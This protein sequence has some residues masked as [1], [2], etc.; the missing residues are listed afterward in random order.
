MKKALLLT[1]LAVIGFGHPEANAQK[2]NEFGST[3]RSELLSKDTYVTKSPAKEGPTVFDLMACP[4]GSVYSATYTEDAAF[5]GS[6]CAD[7]GRPDMPCKFFQH[8]SGNKYLVNGV[9]FY[10]YFNYWD[11]ASYNWLFCTERAGIDENGAMTKPVKF[12]ISFYKDNGPDGLAGDEVYKKVVDLIGTQTGVQTGDDVSGYQS[13][14]YF[15]VELDENIKM[16]SGYLQ[17]SAAA[18]DETPTCWFSVFTASSSVDWAYIDAGDFTMDT[19]NPMIFCFKGTGELAADKA[20]KFNRFISPIANTNGKF[21]RVQVEVANTGKNAIE[22]AKLEL[23]ADGKYLTTEDVEETLDPD[24]IYKHTFEARVDCSAPGT[25]K[26]EVRNVTPGDEKYCPDSLAFIVTSQE[27]TGEV[28]ASSSRDCSY[29]HITNVTIGNVS[30]PSEASNYSDFTDIVADIHAGEVLVLKVEVAG[31]PSIAAWVDWNGN[32]ILGENGEVVTWNT[33]D[34]T[35]EIVI[36]ENTTLTEGNKLL[37]IVANYYTPEPV[38]EYSYGETEDYSINVVRNPG[39]PA[40][41]LEDT[42]LVGSLNADNKTQPFRISNSAQGTLEGELQ[43]SYVLPNTPASNYST[44]DPVG[45]DAL[46]VVRRRIAHEAC[47][48]APAA[49]AQTTYTVRYDN[50]Q[51]AAIG[52]N[53]CDNPIYAQLYPGKML[54]A[55]DG[56]QLS[57][58]DVYIG[59]ACTSSKVI[60]YGANTQSAPGDVITTQEFTAVSDSWNH[61]VLNNP[62]TIDGKDLWVCV[63]VEGF[64]G[65]GYH[66]GIDNGPATRG[67][68]ELINIGQS[69]WWSMA[70]LDLDYNLCIRAN[71]SGEATPAISWLSLDNAH[72]NVAANETEEHNLIFDATKIENNKLYEA[73]IDIL[74]NDELSSKVTMPVYLINGHVTGIQT[75]VTE[76]DTRLNVEGNLITVDASK[77]VANVSLFAINGLLAAAVQGNVLDA[78][79]VANGVYVLVVK[80][81]D[82]TNESMKLLFNK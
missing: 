13:I 80:F 19:F 50:G 3:I 42:E 78:S 45:S 52:I 49:D 63:Q 64:T 15:D 73:V 41:E 40:V 26:L 10:G 44:N 43:I 35:G 24:A 74:T 65:D 1:L 18:T 17:V 53:N 2:V 62:V 5:T 34:H 7:Q 38:G 58:V 51:A 59:D 57:S 11:A 27:A 9:R 67:F 39:T 60:I 68:G 82:G 71:V 70:D 69:K 22:D 6:Q 25:H 4:E 23:W 55:L 20:L 12:E 56:M 33:T 72:I 14:Y 28:G 48:K 29:E 32:G 16:E 66:I 46:K 75:V 31:S 79:N 36:P 81:A 37:R 30:N 77:E 76:N 54:A 8:F 21:E 61:I 47:K